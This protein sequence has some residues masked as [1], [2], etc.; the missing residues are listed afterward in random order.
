MMLQMPVH[1]PVEKTGKRVQGDGPY[2]FPEVI[3]VVPKSAM[4]GDADKIAQPVSDKRAE[5]DDH[6]KGPYPKDYRNGNNC[7]MKCQQ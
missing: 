6:H 3:H 7:R 4:H 1:P 2:T 5:G